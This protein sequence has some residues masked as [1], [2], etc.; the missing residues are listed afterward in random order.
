MAIQ[1]QFD[2]FIEDIREF[3]WGRVYNI[4]H[5]QWKKTGEEFESIGKDYL[6]VTTD[7]ANADGADVGDKVRVIGRLKT[8]RFNKKDGSAGI[9]LNV[10]AEIWEIL[11]KGQGDNRGSEKTGHA[12]VNEI[13]PVAEIPGSDDQ[14]PF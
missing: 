3:D 5:T 14:A 12:A 2:G 6:D 9:A 7:H 8:K 4:S 1:I 13:W 10:R 11:K